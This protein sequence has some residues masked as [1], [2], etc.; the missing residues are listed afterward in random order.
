MNN[1][2]R[3]LILNDSESQ[4]MDILYALQNEKFEPIYER[5]TSLTEMTAALENQSWDLILAD[6]HSEK[7]NALDA[8]AIVQSTHIDI[9]FIVLSSKSGE[10]IAVE[11]MKAGAHDY[12]M[13]DNM[14]RLI[15]AI[16]RELREIEIRT[17]HRRADETIR[18]QSYHDTLTRLPNRALFFDR[19]QQ[20]ILVA[21]RT[22]KQLSILLLEIHNYQDIN[23]NIGI[24]FADILLQQVAS[25]LRNSVR[26]SDTVARL[27]GVKFAI[28]IPDIE[29]EITLFTARKLL[30][31]VQKPF[32][33]D[34]TKTTHI[35]LNMGIS[36]FPEHGYNLDKLLQN[37]DI[38]LQT[39]KK[40]N[41]QFILYRPEHNS[42][43]RKHITLT[44]ELHHAINDQQ[45]F[46]SYQPKVE[47]RSGKIKGVEALIRWQHP[48]HGTVPPDAF[49]P[50]A[51]ETDVIKELSLWVLDE[52]LQQYLKWEE[53]GLILHI[54]VNLSI[55]NLL[56]PACH[57][58][59]IAI[60]DTYNIPSG[61]LEL[62]LT[63]TTMMSDPLTALRMMKT[64]TD[65]GI[66]FSI[67]DFGTGYS[68]LSY[69]KKL[70]VK[71]LKID[72]SFIQDMTKDDNDAVIVR[73][74]IDL[75][76]NL[77]L[78][79]VAEGIEDRATWD[80]LQILRCDMAQGY[81]IS[82]PIPADK[83]YQWMQKCNQRFAKTHALT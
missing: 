19:L 52:A 26:Q 24:H 43:H 51:E 79:V 57:D 80:L 38:A 1:I 42:P 54:A 15:P 3:V 13:K 59:I 37:A 70:P 27:G 8:L 78:I 81:Y 22:K 47:I 71:A 10:N 67:D 20:A 53:Q 16:K 36:F 32:F 41:S 11:A 21:H 23:E 14:K 39:A 35:T 12:I 46:V 31:M 9:P 65:K 40:D 77:G 66:R 63:E 68:S 74:T 29:K 83:V 25:R 58:R 45:L 56:D 72:K 28:L 17:A 82:Q 62:E 64:L 34:S 4:T 55:K 73:A 69:L 2:L 75:A 76:H 18:Y 50:L 61:V 6:Y 33:L 7:Y 44:S 60:I 30:D 5:V 48:Q 49:I